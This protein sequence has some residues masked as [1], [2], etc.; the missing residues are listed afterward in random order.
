VCVGGVGVGGG[1]G[2]GVG[3]GVRVRAQARV[4]ATLQWTVR[5]A[6]MLYAVA[7]ER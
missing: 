6:S 2:V 3:V 5:D 7:R 4:R 1:W